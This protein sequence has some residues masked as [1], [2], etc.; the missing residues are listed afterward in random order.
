MKFP[1]IVAKS[2]TDVIMLKTI[3]ITSLGDIFILLQITGNATST[4][5]KK[6]I[7]VRYPRWALGSPVERRR[8]GKLRRRTGKTLPPHKDA[9]LGKCDWKGEEEENKTTNTFRSLSLFYPPVRSRCRGFLFALDYTQTHITFGRIPLDEGSARRRDLYLTTHKHC[10]RDK[11]PCPQWD[12]NPRSQQAL[13]RRPT[14]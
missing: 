2:V 6:K 12:L 1:D 8:D 3:L 7:N 4:E 14:P 10:T 9:S 11:H 5:K 13:G